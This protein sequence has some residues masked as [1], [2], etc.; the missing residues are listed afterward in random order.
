MRIES[1]DPKLILDPLYSH[2]IAP[3][4]KSFY[5]KSP[6]TDTLKIYALY[7]PNLK[8]LLVADFFPET[9]RALLQSL[10]VLKLERHKGYGT[11]LLEHLEE[12]AKKNN[13]TSISTNFENQE[14]DF[15]N[16]LLDKLNYSKPVT[17][18]TRYFFD[19][20]SFHPDWLV[21]PPPLKEGFK[22]APFSSITDEETEWIKIFTDQG[23]IPPEL[24]PFTQHFPME[25]SN[26]VVLR[27]GD[28]LVGWMATYRISKEVISYSSLYLWHDFR[29]EN[30]AIP[31]LA[32]SIHLHQA[33]PIKY[34]T[35]ELDSRN[36]PPSWDLFVRKRLAP[37]AYNVQNLIYRFKMINIV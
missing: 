13:I 26:S 5:E 28:K 15:L 21:N 10:M 36:V 24:D 25:A 19:I 32:H 27:K 29:M 6:Y 20:P 12:E 2:L 9:N 11:T 3:S 4:F 33:S 22:I 7:D 35:F 18:L 23:A 14:T 16:D 1:V 31:L 34:A 37:Y 17:L 8:G 30:L